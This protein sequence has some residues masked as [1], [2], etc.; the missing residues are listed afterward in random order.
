[1][2]QKL[3]VAQSPTVAAR[4]LGGEMMIMSGQDSTLFTLDEVATIIW[5]SADGLSTLDEIVNLRIC[6]EFDVEPAVAVRDAEALVEE[7]A[8]LGILRVSR[9]PILDSNLSGR[10]P[11]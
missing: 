8:Q 7:L 10:C 2:N 11:K 5:E 3:Y 1:M 4:N 6:P 9:E